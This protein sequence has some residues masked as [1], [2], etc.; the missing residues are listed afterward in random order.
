MTQTSS[1]YNVNRE[2]STASGASHEVNK[3]VDTSGGQVVEISRFS[4][5]ALAAI[6]IDWLNGRPSR[7]LTVTTKDDTRW[8]VRG[9]SFAEV[10]KLLT[11]AKE[12]MALETEKPDTHGK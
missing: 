5:P 6:I 1:G 3:D 4:V 9:K 2:A 10:E 8:H 7:I 11:G 12:M